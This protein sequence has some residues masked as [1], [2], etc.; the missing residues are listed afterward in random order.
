MEFQDIQQQEYVDLFSL[1][2]EEDNKGGGFKMNPDNNLDILDD[3][4][5]NNDEPLEEGKEKGKEGDQE[6]LKKEVDILS[7]EDETKKAGRKPKYDF[8]DMSGYF[9]DRIKNNK[10]VAIEETTENG[11][12]KIFIPKTPE[13]FDE[14]F[15]LQVNYRLE[16]EREENNKAWYESK[17]PAWQ[18]VAQYAEMVDDVQEVLPFIQGVKT[19]ESVSNINEEEI[20]GAEKI[21]RIRLAQNG[22]SEEVIEEQIDAL[23]TTSKLISTAKKMKPIILDAETKYL[24]E[25][26]EQKKQEQLA[27]NNMIQDYRNKAITAIESETFGKKLKQEEKAAVY[28]LIGQPD[29]HGYRIYSAIDNLFEKGDFQ[30]LTE[31]ALFLSKKDAFLSY[32]SN[33]AK[34][35]VAEGL[36]RQLRVANERSGPSAQEQLEDKPVISRNQYTAKFGR[37]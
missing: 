11:E 23:K 13:E 24:K 6:D 32:L 14:V 1:P 33:S 15:E 8:S 10:F 17:S 3:K 26:T 29:A 30:T 20:E 36:Q 21:V 12:K 28:Q 18:A 5:P 31:V 22:D 4:K 34:Q 35:K 19:I 25:I 16:K 37:K 2:K 7:Q 27:Y 9:E